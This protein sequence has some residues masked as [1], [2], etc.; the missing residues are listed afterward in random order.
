MLNHYLIG[1]SHILNQTEAQEVSQLCIT[2]ANHSIELSSYQQAL[3]YSLLGKELIKQFSIVGHLWHHQQS[4]CFKLT[5]AIIISGSMLSRKDL[6]EAEFSASMNHLADSCERVELYT[7]RIHYLI[8]QGK[9]SE[10]N[11]LVRDFLV[12]LNLSMPETYDLEVARAEAAMITETLDYQTLEEKFCSLPMSTNNLSSLL[13][14]FLVA[15]SSAVYLAG[16]HLLSVFTHLKSCFLTWVLSD[17]NKQR[18]NLLS[19]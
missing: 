4:S 15:A 1:R 8:Q 5:Q 16:D 9:V 17:W 18:S 13:T 7:L 6:V 3:D 14:E 12:E 2:A 10:C 11:S 19:G